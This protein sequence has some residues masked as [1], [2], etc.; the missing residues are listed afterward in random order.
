LP[1]LFGLP[2][3]NQ[4]GPGQS[5]VVADLEENRLLLSQF[6]GQVDAPSFCSVQFGLDFLHPGQ[7]YFLGTTKLRSVIEFPEL[8]RQFG[9][10]LAKGLDPGVQSCGIPGEQVLVGGR[11]H[12]CVILA[13]TVNDYVPG[14]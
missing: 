1:F 11:K 14:D 12:V 9:M 4:G 2:F 7:S 8:L 6:V 10:F 5:D 13:V 3:Q